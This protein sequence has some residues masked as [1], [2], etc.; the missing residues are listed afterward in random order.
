MRIVFLA[1][2]LAFAWAALMGQVDLA[3]LALG[4]GLGLLSLWIVAPLFGPAGRRDLRRLPA[5]V[6]L[7]VLF[8]YELVVSGFRVAWDVVTPGTKATPGIV[9]VPLDVRSGHEI[10][11]LANLISLTPGTLS[12]DVSEDR[13]ILYVHS[14]YTDDP[15]ALVADIKSSFES[16]IIEV[17]G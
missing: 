7:V 11:L 3:T 13:S 10:T 17:C 5:A 8:L 1:L 2:V 14:M 12:L 6:R 4:F 9:E 15:E 16:L